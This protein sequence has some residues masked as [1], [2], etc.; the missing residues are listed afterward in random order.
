[1]QPHS[2][3]SCQ[4]ISRGLALVEI[5]CH[6]SCVPLASL[7]LNP[8]SEVEINSDGNANEEQNNSRAPSRRGHRGGIVRACVKGSGNERR[9]DG[10]R[11]LF[12]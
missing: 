7:S 4:E 8:V 10:R 3:T 1:M 9:G 11:L 6:F 5:N 2:S 12:L